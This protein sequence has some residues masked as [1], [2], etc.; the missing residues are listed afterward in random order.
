VKP[1]H[2]IRFLA[3]AVDLVGVTDNGHDKRVG[4]IAYALGERLG[5]PREQ[6][7]RLFIAGLL[8]DIGVSSTDAHDHL[9][10]EDQWGK[11]DLHCER[12]ERL[13]ES[14][15][16]LAPFA[17]VIRNHHMQWQAP[18]SRALAPGER[19][20]ANLIFLADRLDAWL[21]PGVRAREHALARA[22]A[23]MGSLFSP[24]FAPAVL[25]AARDPVFWADIARARLAQ[26]VDEILAAIA[27]PPLSRP[28]RKSVPFLM[29]AI[30][31]AKC[32][33]TAEHSFR[34]AAIARRLGEMF[35]LPAPDC[36]DLETA[37]LLHDIGKLAIPDEIINKPGPLTAAEMAIMRTHAAHSYDVILRL[38]SMERIAELARQHHEQDDG[39]GYPDGIGDGA[40]PLTARI[41]GAADV[42]QALTQ[43]RAYRAG[44]DA[45]Q[46]LDALA[47][48]ESTGRLDRGVLGMLKRR[49][50]EFWSLARG[51]L[52]LPGLSPQIARLCVY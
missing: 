50:G 38:P 22:M 45:T 7:E 49:F 31:D 37:G 36:E 2:V 15:D 16:C 44:M 43:T 42:F 19:V 5:L 24:A 27:F 10:A 3:D 14:L 12:G 1:H 23:A 39:G 32:P 51:P 13:A 48:A 21:A 9:V 28:D 47:L 34:V 29:A 41:L 52:E 33:Y 4:L 35:M 30:V 46:V 8:H 25:A 17:G 26:R 11:V 20:D 18:E 40:L 6:R